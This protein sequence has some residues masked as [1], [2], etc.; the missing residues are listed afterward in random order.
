MQETMCLSLSGYFLL[1]LF[2]SLQLAFV[3]PNSLPSG[4]SAQEPSATE[5][6]LQ[7]KVF[8]PLTGT[9]MKQQV[10]PSH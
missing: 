5:N 2:L 8:L 9:E 1:L 4:N 3:R 7:L 6:I 10:H